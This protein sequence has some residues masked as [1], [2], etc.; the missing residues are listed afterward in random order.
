MTGIKTTAINVGPLTCA[1]NLIV[2]LAPGTIDM[3]TTAAVIEHPKFGV[4]LWDTGINDAV[5]DPAA[6]TITGVR[7]C[8]R[9]SARTTSPASTQ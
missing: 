1:K 7:D 4:V 8:P 3:P 9:L 2:A 6:P 5:A